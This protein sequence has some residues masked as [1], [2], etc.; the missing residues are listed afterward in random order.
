VLTCLGFFFLSGL[1]VSGDQYLDSNRTGPSR[2]NYH[3]N[4]TSR[5]LANSIARFSRS[6]LRSSSAL[7]TNTRPNDLLRLDYQP[8]L[9][10]A[11]FSTTS[12]SLSS[13]DN[14][15]SPSSPASTSASLSPAPPSSLASLPASSSTASPEPQLT[16]FNHQ[17][18]LVR[19]FAPSLSLRSSSILESQS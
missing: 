2:L 10:S 16:H 9:R 12:P 7:P 8:Y 3:N 5:R 18:G 6:N 11:T 13:A 17:T 19:R 14:K 1:L 15:V 4:N